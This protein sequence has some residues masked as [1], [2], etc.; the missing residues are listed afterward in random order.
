[1]G[2]NR[3][4]REDIINLKRR[5]RKR[6]QLL[7]GSVI[8]GLVVLGLAVFVIY[9]NVSRRDSG[10]H[11]STEV[12]TGIMMDMEEASESSVVSKHTSTDASTA[13]DYV[14]ESELADNT[15]VEDTTE[16]NTT[17]ENTS[18]EIIASDF[19]FEVP[20]TSL[21]LVDSIEG[22]DWFNESLFE[23]AE[24]SPV[25][26]SYFNNTVF[27][28]DS[29]TEGM[30]IYSGVPYLNGFC[31]KGLSVDKLDSDASIVI[32]GHDEAY[33]CY[34]AISNTSF[35][36]YYCMFGVNEL[37][38]VS[39]DVFI[40]EFSELIDHIFSVN[41]DAVVYVESILPVTEQSSAES[42]I[43]TQERIN[44]YN[45]LLLEMCQER[46]DVIYLDL[47]AAVSNESGYLPDEA[48]TDGIHCTSDYC[49]RMI[50]YIR[51]N[52]FIRK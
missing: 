40:D 11:V 43:Y 38:W 48:S 17:E 2:R 1:M 47:A 23:K 30:L 50:Q 21:P 27:I 16:E 22:D 25:D 35:D 9:R 44:E 49:K 18:E 28:G 34:D 7:A 45:D 6:R 10:S 46:G 20:E 51:C 5:R 26:M 15:T 42:D 3:I 41:P 14:A 13:D 39:P 19:E 36:N 24:I 29:R 12:T 31:Y 33:T 8:S 37:G 52:T 4:T 32:S